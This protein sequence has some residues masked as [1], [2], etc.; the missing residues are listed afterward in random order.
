MTGGMTQP[1]VYFFGQG[2][3]DGT[4]AM[5]DLLGGKGAGLAEMTNIGI[6]VPPGFTIASSICIAYLESRHFPPR[7]QQQVEA[8]LQR[9]E[10]ATGKIFGG[11]SDPLLVS[12]RS[13]AAVSMPGHDG[14]DPQPR[15]QRRDRRRPRDAE[16]EPPL[17]LGLLPA[18]RPDVRL[19]GLRP[20]EAP[21]RGDAGG[22][23]EG[24]QGVARH[25][26]PRRRHAGA[27]EGVQGVHHLGHRQGLPGQAGR[28]ALGRHRGRL[29][30]LAHQARRGLPPPAR[31]PGLD[32]HGGQHR[33]DGLRQPGRG[34][35]HRR[36]LHPGPVDRRAGAVRRVPAERA[37]RGRGERLARSRTDREA[38][39]NAAGSVHRVRA[40]GADAGTAFPRCPGPRVHHRKRQALPAPDPARP[41]HRPC[42]GPDRLRDG[43]RRTD[44]AGG[45]R[46]THSPHGPRP[47]PASDDRPEGRAGPAHHRPS[48]VAG[49]GVGRG[50]L[51]R[52]PRRGT[53]QEGRGGHPGAPGDQP[54]G[55]PRDDPGQGHSHGARRHDL[56]CRGRGARHG[57]AVR[58]RRAGDHGG[59]GGGRLCRE[60]PAGQGRGVD[61]AG[62]RHRT[63]PG[64][65]RRARQ[66]GGVR[67]LRPAPR[68][69]RQGPHAPHPRER[70]HA[71]RRTQGSRFRRRGDRPLPHRAHVLR[72]RPTLRHA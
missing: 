47:A 65:A 18:L 53:R 9:L 46:R 68:L 63:R 7:L 24:R 66:S 28:P 3:A 19:R 31:H 37:G 44:Y 38:S 67:Q 42:V 58:G 61:H 39:A 12:V 16:Q 27:G 29:R 32:G 14:D 56:S 21:L 15:P 8:A 71:R 43:R 70:R 64:R 2:R 52:R 45:G 34:V 4:A 33:D 57:Q 20:A 60:R 62:R 54:G 23:E 69:G 59:R 17:R 10:A 1:L 72:G 36:G 50:R 6:P 13:G 41:A 30:E 22:A 25:R 51:H 49:R 48:G 35:R 40:G 5:K 26:P 11:A 55:L